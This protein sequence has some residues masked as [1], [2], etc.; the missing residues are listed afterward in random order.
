MVKMDV[1]QQRA[2][3]DLIKD[4]RDTAIRNYKDKTDD[5]LKKIYDEEIKQHSELYAITSANTQ[6]VP[7]SEQRKV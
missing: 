2:V 5:I 4:D 6:K 1:A 7:K 3:F